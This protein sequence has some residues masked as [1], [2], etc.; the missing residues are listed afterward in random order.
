MRSPR[1]RRGR[2]GYRPRVE[3][4]EPRVLFSVDVLT[5]HNDL[6]RTGQDLN[7]TV[8]TPANV[9][10]NSFGKLFSYPVDGAVYVQPLYL[11]GQA[12]PGQGTHD[13]VYVATENDSVYA[14][15][16]NG[17]GGVL[18]QDSFTNPSAGITSVPSSDIGSSAILPRIGI[19]G[20]PVIDPGTGTLYVV[21]L[22]K[23]FVNSTTSYV[24][25]LHALDVTTGTEKFG[26]PVVIQASVPG[27]GPDAVNGQVAFTPMTELQRPGLLLFN[28]VVY[29][30]WAS[31]DDRTPYHG[32]VMGYNAQTL[33]QTA[34]L[35]ASPNGQEA[36][37]WMSG[38][39][40]AVDA[41]GNIYLTT[42]NGTFD[43]NTGGPDYGE[44]ILKLATAG[45]GLTVADWFT[46]FNYSAL[47]AQDADFGSGGVVLLP[48]QAGA[49]PHELITAGKQ[50][51][52]YL[53][54][55]DNLGHFD[56]NTDYVV[57]TVSDV[58]HG[59]FDTPAYFNN[60]VYYHANGD[61]LKAY[62]LTN[63]LL[64]A[65]PVAQST[66]VANFPGTTP[67]VS[68]DGTTNGI[69]W[70]WQFGSPGV[71]H[72]YDA[73]TL[74][75][76][77]NSG[78][79]GQRDQAGAGVKF[80]VPTIANGKVYVGTQNGLTVFGLLPQATT[81]PAAPSGLTATAPAFSQVML[82]WTDNS[83]SEWGFKIQRSTD[84]VHYTTI[85]E[86]GANV[87]SFTDTTVSGGTSYSYQVVATNN[88]GDSAPAGP[89]SVTTPPGQP[90][91]GLVGYWPF[92]EGAG[93]TTADASGN[94]D[95]GTVIG[96]TTW[97]AGKIGSAALS[98]HGVG[99]ADAHVQIPDAPQLRFTAAQDFT[100]AA[101]V[102][103]YGLQNRWQGVVT[104]S[105][106]AYPTY[107]LWISADNH[108]VSGSAFQNLVGP[109]ATPGW[110][111]VTIVQDAAANQ[112]RLYVDGVL[113]DTAA[114]AEPANGPGDLWVGGAAAAAQ[115]FNGAVDDVRIYN[116]TLSAAEIRQLASNSLLGSWKFDERSGTTTADA[117]GNG[118]AG[119][120]VGGV[121]WTADQFG[122]SAV[123][124]AGTGSHVDI[125][126]PGGLLAF[127]AAQSFTLAAWVDVTA[128]PGQWQGI[129]TKSM[130]QGPAYG[131]WLDPDNRW[132]ADASIQPLVGPVATPGWHQVT[133]VQDAAANQC[134]LYVDG[135]LAGTAPQT[136][137]ANGP[138]DL[139]IG[140][141]ETVSQSFTGAVDDVRVYS[142]ALAEAE[143]Q[144]LANGPLLGY[145]KFDEGSGTTAAD[146]SGNGA[147]GTLVGAVSWTA[148]QT[149]DS[150][151]Q[152]AGSGHVDVPDPSGRLAFTVAQSFTLAAWVDVTALPGQWQGIV[153]KSMGHWPAYGLWLD[154]DN[155]WLSGSSIQN[156]VGPVATLG[157]HQVTIVQDAVANQR[158]LYVDGVLVGSAPQAET[159]N[160]P[161]DL[162]I[163]GADT[164]S[165]FFT[166]AI[167][168]VRIYDGALSSAAVA[169]LA[170]PGLAGW[171]QFN[172][173]S[174]TTAGDATGNGSTGTLG[175]T[176]TWMSSPPPDSV[177][178]S[179]AGG[180][181]VGFSGGEG[182]VDVPDPNGLLRF[183]ANQSFSLSTWVYVPSL[184]GKLTGIVT[185][186]TDAGP[187][188]G[189]WIDA[190]N[191]W[192]FHSTQLTITGTAV[193]LG[194]HFVAITQDSAGQSRQL[195]VDGVLAGSAP[196]SFDANGTGDLW[197]GGARAGAAYAFQGIVDDVRV[198]S[199]ALSAGEVQRLASAGTIGGGR[200]VVAAVAVADE[201][202]A[203]SGDPIPVPQKVTPVRK[204]RHRV[205]RHRVRPH[206]KKRHHL[207]KSAAI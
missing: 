157:W 180:A 94:N 106:D 110:H 150:A 83:T 86:V 190:G 145:W 3:E 54:D 84:G 200:T 202:V 44:A 135:V 49:H 33:Q 186:G 127:T 80:T 144:Q 119:T 160:G 141:A 154:P 2:A 52:I 17:T 207:R 102:D 85:N 47:N 115:F 107:G 43:A 70:D 38:A 198:Y 176:A 75:E 15:D 128:L 132:V 96:E 153:T 169:Q 131:L 116:R 187:S 199:R 97:V 60:T 21:A 30:S 171:W 64:S 143:V 76:L 53:A 36:G 126:D 9:N 93:T 206:H 28:G 104:K 7:E 68:A 25:R 51:V 13:V 109:V 155:H 146:A 164:V 95:D 82:S 45:G 177:A 10:A 61:T 151:V 173:G 125:P 193:T 168:E 121:S 12:I 130:G 26:G 175:G 201:P 67:S 65:A 114:Q 18:W 91:P 174:G 40:P 78:Q 179:L 57:Q 6:A 149:G 183:T 136:E 191:H 156:L 4:F 140:G 158:R 167:D 204:H 42:G 69:V 66:T 98:F 184:P 27:T 89:I 196:V 37:I 101:W 192:A 137:A 165:Q 205:R 123:Q 112:R 120:L 100:L 72:A 161:G 103:V 90:V 162:W 16:A 185:K 59:A 118:D 178:P 8:L 29:I 147:T 35:N 182:H 34:V 124:F 71:L 122:G 170:N 134:L 48:D 74:A 11:S 55:R 77:Y 23:E 163:G 99:V 87:T 189:I 32:W 197:I 152:F 24:Q 117:S 41:V 133:L 148:D 22:T 92:D 105:A 50:G 203:P 129:V 31:Y 88:A 166:G 14:F 188:Y 139:W 111:Q 81:A 79:A 172:E 5:Y 113:V 73:G 108:W 39:A 142:Q 20:T 56:P 1:N 62:S 58:P 181:G 46:P 159:A 195:Y 194:W 63:G 19:T 138:G